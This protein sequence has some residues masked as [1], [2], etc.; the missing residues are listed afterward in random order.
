MTD[1]SAKPSLAALPLRGRDLTIGSIPRHLIMFS[2]PMLAGNALQMGHSLI[3]AFWVGQYL[4]ENAMAAIALSMPVVFVLI[5]AGAGLTLASSI[6]ISQHFG[7]KDS[8]AIR[9]VVNSSTILV[10]AC[11]LVLVAVGELLTPAILRAM[12]AKGEVLPLAEGYMRIFLLSLP[13]GYGL[14]LTR[15]M[16]QGTGDSRTPLYY[17]AVAVGINAVLDPV[18]MLG[19]MK[20]P[21]LGLNGTAWA[22]LIA[23]GVA[24]G[25]LV[26][27][28]RRQKHLEAP[29]LHWRAFD[30]RT[31][32]ITT[33]IG[34]PS[35][36]QQSL[37][38]VSMVFV[39][40]IVNSFGDSATAA[41]GIAMRIDML[42]FMPALALSMAVSMLAGQNIGAGKHH[43]IRQIVLWGCV[44]T[45]GFTLAASALAVGVPTLLMRIFINDENVIRLG[46]DYLR[47]VGSCYV[48]FAFMFVTNGVINGAGH[49]MMTTIFS[50]VSLWAVRVPL[51]VWLSHRMG[52][53]GVWYAMAAS[54]AVS[55]LASLAY[56]LSGH[57]RRPVARRPVPDLP[58]AA[59]GEE[60]GEA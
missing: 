16:L 11:S 14:F 3:N 51:A 4:G 7:A 17:Q 36:L 24:L 10:A 50:L 15:S 37:V 46:S 20:V 55:M 40:G 35:A 42:A 23:Q 21:A 29:T 34:I 58:A 6:L 44:L 39:V 2:L 45:G 47:I 33:R 53:N 13:T 56:Y 8:E 41:F 60:S 38:S 31:A 32:W 12:G 18:L 30:A 5:A 25:A 54:F 49:T 59:F 43:R 28:L 9:R 57:W 19:W 27:V 22:T 1:Q 26:V 48:F 52:L